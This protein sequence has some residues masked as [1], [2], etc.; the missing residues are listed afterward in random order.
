VFQSGPSNSSRRASIPPL[1]AKFTN[2][3]VGGSTDAKQFLVIEGVLR[4]AILRLFIG[5]F[6]LTLRTLLHPSQNG[7]YF[8][9]GGGGAGMMA[10]E[11]PF[12]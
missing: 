11:K 8:L 9:F 4:V 6:Y 7:R 10:S 12:R 5:G 2:A 1:A 3:F